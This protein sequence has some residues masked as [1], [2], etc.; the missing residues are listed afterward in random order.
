MSKKNICLVLLLYTPIL[1]VSIFIGLLFLPKDNGEPY[2][3]TIQKGQ[4]IIAVSHALQADDKIFSRYVL[5]AGAYILGTH[6]QLTQGSYRLP[7]HLSSWTILHR[8]SEGNPDKVHIQIIEGMRWAKMRK[9][10]NE[11]PNIQHDSINMSDQELLH[12][13][14]PEANIQHAEGWFFPDNYVI[15]SG[16]SDI[17]IFRAAYQAMQRELQTAWDNRADHLPYK[18]PYELLIMASLIEKE[19]ADPADRFNISS[20]FINRLNK[21]MR[22]QTD[23]TVIYGMGDLYQGKIR[24]ADLQRDTP[25]NTYTRAGLPPTPIAL[26]SRA[27]LTAAAHPAKSEYLFFVSRQ[28]NT[29]RSQFSQTLEQ[30][31]AAVRQYILK[32]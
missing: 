15:A 5:V 8:L 11:T 20:V 9:I 28:D 22:L 10:I 31:N 6:N 2:T 32:K 18:T 25:Y 7:A 29:G 16:S 26:P 4:G 1:L 30:H 27:A 14:A 12:T 21:N 19:T 3:L 13:I 17:Q 24:K 23:P